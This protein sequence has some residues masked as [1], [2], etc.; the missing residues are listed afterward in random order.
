MPDIFSLAEQD[1]VIERSPVKKKHR[2]A[3][4]QPEKT[5]WTAHQVRSIVIEVA[6]EFRQL[7]T[8]LALTDV[9]IGEA[10][11]LKWKHLDFEKQALRIEQSLWY[12]E[13]V[14]P[15]TKGSN[16]LILFGDKLNQVM[17]EHLVKSCRIGSEDFV[18]AKIDGY[19]LIRMFF[20]AMF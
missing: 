19:L 14:S 9:R 20:V 11:G 7:F 17:T 16:R 2:P 10:L 4:R 13:L 8:L 5:V 1:E 15:K 3:V 6:A 18:F 12:G